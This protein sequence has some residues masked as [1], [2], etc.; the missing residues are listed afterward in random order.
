MLILEGVL[1]Y[2]TI[3]ILD[4]PIKQLG[5]S[6]GGCSGGSRG[7]CDPWDFAGE[8]AAG[9]ECD[10]SG[11]ENVHGHCIIQSGRVSIVLLCYAEYDQD[12]VMFNTITYTQTQVLFLYVV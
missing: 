4:E 6:C 1:D 9:L 3:D 8:C 7:I 2:Y 11:I 12:Y 5:E 10:E